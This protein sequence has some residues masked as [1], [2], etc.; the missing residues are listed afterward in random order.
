MYH[1]Y[2]SR[3]HPSEAADRLSLQVSY[4]DF[5][6]RGRPWALSD[7]IPNSLMICPMRFQKVDLTSSTRMV[8]ASAY[9]S[10]PII[11]SLE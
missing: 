7:I 6:L 11:G 8:L 5:L 10:C 9:G 1:R 3:E 2:R 4:V